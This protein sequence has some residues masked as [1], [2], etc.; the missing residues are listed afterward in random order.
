VIFSKTK[1]AGATL[2]DLERRADER[3]SFARTFCERE[4]V[5][6]GLPSRFPQCNLSHN[7][8][9]GT[10]RGMHFQAPPT[11]ESKLVRC[12]SGAIFDVIVDLR[13]GSPTQLDWL[14]VELSAA[15]GRAL[16][17]PVGF[18]HGFITLEDETSIYY[19]MGDFYRAEGASGF[20][21]ND[22]R[23]GI[24]WPRSPT[25]IAERDAGY[26]DLDPESLN[27]PGF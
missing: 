27:A 13:S 3:G 11:A 2:V 7:R 6:H 15:N 16:F 25:T 8:L 5:A 19:H 26:P 9:A 23:V 20:R 18:A 14:G 1:L 24:V 12:V 22:P 4:F 17:V 10:L 21:W